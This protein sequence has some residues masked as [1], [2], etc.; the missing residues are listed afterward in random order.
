MTHIPQPDFL[1]A[2]QGASSF[3]R[4]SRMEGSLPRW[5]LGGAIATI[6]LATAFLAF[7]DIQ[8][9]RARI[10]SNL[11]DRA[12]V[13]I[14]ALEGGARTMSPGNAEQEGSSRLEYEG[15]GR[16][17]PPA[18]QGGAALPFPFRP[19]PSQLIPDGR[20]DRQGHRG[21][22]GSWHDTRRRGMEESGRERHSRLP[23]LLMAEVAKQP[24]ILY[25]AIVDA[26]GV[27]VGHSIP[28]RRGTLLRDAGQFSLPLNGQFQTRLVVDGEE[29]VY[30][31]AKE[32]TPALLQHRKNSPNFGHLPPPSAD[33]AP[34]APQADTRPAHPRPSTRGPLYMFVGMDAA[35][36]FAELDDAVQGTLLVSGLV[37]IAGTSALFLLYYMTGY[38]RSRRLLSDT[39]AF[40][41]QMVTALPIGLLSCT[42]HGEVSMYNSH[43]LTLLG[44]PSAPASIYD[45]P[46][47]DW[48]GMIKEIEQGGLIF[49]RE[50]NLPAPLGGS[51]AISASA[52][53][54]QDGEGVLTG[55]LFILRDLGEVKRLQKELR[56]SERLSALGN[57]AAGVAHE[58]R[59]PLSSIKGYATYL[60]SK[61]T[62]D[63]T[64]RGTAHRIIEETERLNRVVSDLLSVA[65]PGALALAP[66]PAAQVLHRA[67]SLA[68]ASAQEKGLALVPGWEG[69]ENADLLLLADA[70][71]LVQA[72]LNILLN[73][74]QATE[75]EG[76][77]TVAVGAPVN[78]SL[79]PQGEEEQAAADTT[80]AARERPLLLPLSFTDTGCGMDEQ[81]AANL[82]TPYFTTRANGTGLGLTIT[83]QIIEMHGGLVKVASRP[84]SGTCFTVFLPLARPPEPPTGTPLICPAPQQE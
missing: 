74:V 25:I 45:L 50:L 48:K 8:Q 58:V 44:L 42:R 83:H 69:S 33:K 4:F 3:T 19:G 41:T 59:N 66:V 24:G 37:I 40:A 15:A 38:R 39:A 29:S 47:L 43:S 9:A 49:E 51:G 53:P 70:D 20:I 7:R 17:F 32:F 14:L 64:A 11:G 61:L 67:V 73:A 12:S 65:R 71:R 31:V 77:V 57:M 55:F 2:L 76:T 54:V 28:G 1:R 18:Q 72:F 36:A 22:H 23:S 16:G 27:V 84:G 26:N 81:T 79:L 13:L 35:P 78:N 62:Q 46:H 80:P 52:A 5:I 30:E 75:A 63:E 82:F 21:R 6:I 68:T 10:F 56:L 60:A 34:G